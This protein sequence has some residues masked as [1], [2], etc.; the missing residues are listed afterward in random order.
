LT[1]P[2]WLEVYDGSGRRVA[3]EMAPTGAVRRFG[4]GP[5]KLLL[6]NAAAVQLS[7]DGRSA[8]IPP[9]LVARNVAWIAV[10]PR[11][12]VIQAESSRPAVRE[13]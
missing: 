4:R 12:A 9:A 8:R 1:A 7:L 3:F 13:N 2:C 5:W 11:G 10:D 6:G